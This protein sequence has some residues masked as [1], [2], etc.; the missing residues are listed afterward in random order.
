MPD[1]IR[2]FVATEL[3]GPI[4][5]GLTELQECLKRKAPPNAVRWVQ[6]RDIHLT[7]KFLGP[8]R[9]DQIE[10][11]AQALGTAC[12]PFLALTYTVSGLG[13]FPNLRRPRVIWVGVEELSGGLARLQGAIEAAC[14]GLGFEREERGFDPHLTLGRLRDQA[15]PAD[16]RAIGDMVQGLEKPFLGTATVEGISLIRSDLQPAGPVYTVLHRFELKGS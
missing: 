2:A 12:A 3:P 4:K 14:A 8:T 5:A 1:T 10:P 15:A 11:L 16:Q 9:M 7:L 13:C 6:A